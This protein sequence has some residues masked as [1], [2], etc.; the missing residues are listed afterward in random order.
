[1]VTFLQADYSAVYLS[2][3]NIIVC[4]QKHYGEALILNGVRQL[5]ELL[6]EE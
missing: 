5:H 4:C 3:C 2:I 6:V 1:M